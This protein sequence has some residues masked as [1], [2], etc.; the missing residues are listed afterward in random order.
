MPAVKPAPTRS[1]PLHDALVDADT[2]ARL[3]ASAQRLGCDP[4][5][6][7]LDGQ[8]FDMPRLIELMRRRG[9]DV[10]APVRP[11]QQPNIKSGQVMWTVAVGMPGAR[12]TLAFFEPATP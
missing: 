11:Q 6:I 12:L 4:F 2:K 9:Y 1:S 8:H 7:S 5:D 3:R 10:G